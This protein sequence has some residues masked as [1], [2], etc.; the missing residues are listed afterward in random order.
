MLAALVVGVGTIAG[1]VYGTWDWI[2]SRFEDEP[3]PAKQSGEIAP[4]SAVPGTTLKT[5]L[6]NHPTIERAPYIGFKLTSLGVQVRVT[7]HLVGF[8]RREVVIRV[9]DPRKGFLGA[10]TPFEPPVDDF[11]GEVDHW[12]PYSEY[13]TTYGTSWFAQ[14]Y[15]ELVDGDTILDSFKTKQ[16]SD[17]R[18][19]GC[20][21]CPPLAAPPRKLLVPVVVASP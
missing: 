5:Y 9:S 18:P 2:T 11:K 19:Q 16:F 17:P 8:G 14:A 3:P 13:L 1:G 7:I 4:H 12:A 21:G 6:K 20:V 15:I 10:A